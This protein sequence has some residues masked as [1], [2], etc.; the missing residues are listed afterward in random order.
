MERG[1]FH[2]SARRHYREVLQAAARRTIV[3]DIVV[4]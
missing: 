1:S 4:S 2:T 3:E